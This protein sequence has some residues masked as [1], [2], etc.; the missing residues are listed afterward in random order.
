MTV[1]ARLEVSTRAN[2]SQERPK[3]RMAEACAAR[4]VA[5]ERPAAGF[6]GFVGG[7]TAASNAV[8]NTWL[9]P[10]AAKVVALDKLAGRF[11]GFNAAGSLERP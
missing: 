8:K 11:K 7:Q 9:G 1:P 5:L 3:K 4:V 10:V 2:G 6:A